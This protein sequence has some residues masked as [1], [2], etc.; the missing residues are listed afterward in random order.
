MFILFSSLFSDSESLDYK[1]DS[2]MDYNT[3]SAKL[4]ANKFNEPDNRWDNFFWILIVLVIIKRFINFLFKILWIPF[5]IALIYY[6]LKYLGY[7]FTNL[8]NVLNN[9]SLGIIDWFYTK[10]TKILNYF[11]NRNE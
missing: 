2:K 6:L 8:F 7:D 10:I 9:L 11:F 3:L 1:L 5:K 4:M